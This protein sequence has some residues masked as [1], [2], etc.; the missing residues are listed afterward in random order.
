MNIVL[1][2]SL[3]F[4]TRAAAAS[5]FNTCCGHCLLIVTRSGVLAH[6]QQEHGAT[7][8]TAFPDK[9]LLLLNLHVHLC[10]VWLSVVEIKP[11][12]EQ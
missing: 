11:A 12:G 1:D 7:R 9:S 3:K 8:T 4:E 10:S 6:V 5:T 2:E